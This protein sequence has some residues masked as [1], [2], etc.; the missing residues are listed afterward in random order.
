MLSAQISSL[1]ALPSPTI[2]SS[3][4]DVF[5]RVPHEEIFNLESPSGSPVGYSS[6]DRPTDYREAKVS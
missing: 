1:Q 2:K 3:Q 5:M 4:P 6:I